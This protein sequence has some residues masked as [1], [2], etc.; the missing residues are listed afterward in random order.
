[1]AIAKHMQVYTDRGYII[2]LAVSVLL[3]SRFSKSLLHTTEQK[4]MH[5]NIIVRQVM[6]VAC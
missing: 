3:H 6:K 5:F 4:T 1:M 2:M